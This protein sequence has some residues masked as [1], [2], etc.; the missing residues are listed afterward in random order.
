MLSHW[1]GWDRGS[2]SEEVLEW[3]HGCGSWGLSMGGG[4]VGASS[5][6]RSLLVAL[7]QVMVT[8]KNYYFPPTCPCYSAFGGL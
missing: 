4:T 5:L 3:A 2:A 1:P 8:G 6:T 7:G